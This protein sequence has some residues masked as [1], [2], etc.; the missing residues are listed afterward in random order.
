MKKRIM[1][2]MLALT[3][4]TLTAC[5][6]KE[7]KAETGTDG[8]SYAEVYEDG[9]FNLNLLKEEV[10]PLASELTALP[11]GTY[12]NKDQEEYCFVRVPL[13]YLCTA[14]YH[15]KGSNSY[16]A[17]MAQGD[18]ELQQALDRGLLKQKYSVQNITLTNPNLISPHTT[19]TYGIYIA[20]NTDYDTLLSEYPNGVELQGTNNRAFYYV[21]ESEYATTDL[22]LI[23]EINNKILLQAKY[24]GPM[25]DIVGIDKIAYNIYNAVT[26]K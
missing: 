10:Y 11:M 20:D 22:V 26:L 14:S 5:G 6:D 7:D 16:V 23:Y 9:N 25:A 21:D 17:K 4:L 13:N 1:I 3:A 24:E 19:I 12:H 15:D 8:I 2:L 18:G